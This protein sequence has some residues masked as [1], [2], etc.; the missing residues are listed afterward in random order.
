MLHFKLSGTT[1][2]LNQMSCVH[3]KPFGEE[4]DKKTKNKWVGNRGKTIVLTA[5]KYIPSI[6]YVNFDLS[7]STL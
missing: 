4:G 3:F 1:G 5:A 7:V 2:G 6:I